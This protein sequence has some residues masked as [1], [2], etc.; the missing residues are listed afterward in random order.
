[1]GCGEPRPGEGGRVWSRP[2]ELGLQRAG[3]N[4][5]RG[6]CAH[7]LGYSVCCEGSAADKPLKT[8]PMALCHPSLLQMLPTSKTGLILLSAYRATVRGCGLRPPP[9]VTGQ[10]RESWKIVS[11]EG[12]MMAQGPGGSAPA[13]APENQLPVTPGVALGTGGE[14][15][16]PGERTI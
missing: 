1:M 15:E 4:E 6:V 2:G 16:K 13:W 11:G 3:R 10:T 14:G 5:G 12:Q 8:A 9:D 7:T